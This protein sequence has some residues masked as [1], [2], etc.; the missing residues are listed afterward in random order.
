M[1]GFNL[2]P[3]ASLFTCRNLNIPAF[4]EKNFFGLK[5]A[6]TC[7]FVR[8]SLS[9]R[10]LE[11]RYHVLRWRADL[12][13]HNHGFQ[14]QEWGPASSPLAVEPASRNTCYVMQLRPRGTMTSTNVCT[15]VAVQQ[16]H[17]RCCVLAGSWQPWL[18]RSRGHMTGSG[19]NRSTQ[20]SLQQLQRVTLS[21][22]MTELSGM[23]T[24]DS[25]LAAKLVAAAG[26][27][28]CYRR[29]RLR[30]GC[31]RGQCLFY[32]NDHSA[33]LHQKHSADQVTLIVSM[34]LYSMCNN[35]VFS[36]WTC[37]TSPTS[38]YVPPPVSSFFL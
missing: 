14:K 12:L 10:R 26:D 1:V 3:N 2:N 11:G 24:V 36:F 16:T 17:H 35:G 33:T 32:L 13:N 18:H 25:Q 9:H 19:S 7:A 4:F 23:L 15:D 6:L 20:S 8:F 30:W 27:P 38:R 31:W 29:Q 34:F 22:S 37:W 28:R 5:R 21:Q